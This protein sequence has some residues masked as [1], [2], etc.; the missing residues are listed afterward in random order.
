MS[1]YMMFSLVAPTTNP[2]N[3]IDNRLAP[4]RLPISERT[5]LHFSNG[6]RRE[7]DE[8]NASFRRR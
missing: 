2:E 7:P 1:R 8:F 5:P 3:A 6:E 4:F